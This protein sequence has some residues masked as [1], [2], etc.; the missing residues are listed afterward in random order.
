MRTARAGSGSE[1]RSVALFTAEPI[2]VLLRPCLSRLGSRLGDAG[3]LRSKS[4]NSDDSSRS[5]VTSSGSAYQQR[6]TDC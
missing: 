4:A 1:Y 2:G 5:N 3:G 6:H